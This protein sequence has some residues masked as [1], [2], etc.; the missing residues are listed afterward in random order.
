MNKLYNLYLRTLKEI[1]P[2]IKYA[3]KIGVM[4]GKDCEIQKKV[5]WGSE[6]YLIKIGD[7]VRVTEGVRFIT[8]DGG[9]WVFRKT[10]LPDADKFGPITVGNNVH[11]GMNSIIMP[12]VRIGN[13]VVI[14][15]GA[16]VT[17]D[18]KDNTVVGG[19][20]A[21]EI[22]SIDTYYNKIK[23][24]IDLTKKYDSKQKKNYLLTKYKDYWK[25]VGE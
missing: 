19:V 18:V 15:C 3:R 12:G 8:H 16:V 14:A 17:K 13:N 20:P 5:F 11:I 10:L 2:G 1:L 22:E 7:H 25:E 4:V 24:K 9:L 21:K 6:P 23:D